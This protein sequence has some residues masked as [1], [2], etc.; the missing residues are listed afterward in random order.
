MGF[1]PLF[2]FIGIQFIEFKKIKSYLIFLNIPQL[3][4]QRARLANL[5]RR[6]TDNKP[7]VERK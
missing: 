1:D 4:R 6:T 5:D 7:I 3:K 2:V